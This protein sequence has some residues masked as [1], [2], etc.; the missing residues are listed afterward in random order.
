MS[1]T[2]LGGYVM[3]TVVHIENAIKRVAKKS[4]DPKEAEARL[5][6]DVYKLQLAGADNDTI[7]ERIMEREK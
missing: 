2:D 3:T 4:A 1:D 5:R 7:L 6:L